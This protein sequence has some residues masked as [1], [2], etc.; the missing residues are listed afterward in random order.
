[1]HLNVR[2]VFTLLKCGTWLPAL[3]VMCGPVRPAPRWRGEIEHIPSSHRDNGS[4][5]SV[6]VHPETPFPSNQLIISRVTVSGT[7]TKHR[8]KLYCHLDLAKHRGVLAS[9]ALKPYT[10]FKQSVTDNMTSL[11]ILIHKMATLAEE[12]YCLCVN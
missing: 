6:T 12:V 11:L 2:S 4:P 7:C 9:R 10:V 3:A 1:M 8:K 5:W